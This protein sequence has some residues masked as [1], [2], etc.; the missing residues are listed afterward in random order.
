MR[1]RSAITWLTTLSVTAL[2]SACNSG[3]DGGGSSES[4]NSGV[5]K[6]K[7][8]QDVTNEEAEAVCEAFASYYESK[9]D[10][11]SFQLSICRWA[12]VYATASAAD[13]GTNLDLNDLCDLAYDACVDCLDNPGTEGC[14]D[15]PTFDFQLDESCTDS[16]PP[17]DCD[18]TVGE[19]ETCLK[20]EVDSIVG[21]FNG[22]PS[23]GSLTQ[24]DLDEASAG[25]EEP[26]LPGACTALEDT[27]PAVLE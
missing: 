5:Q 22:A 2:T 17:Q 12:A 25:L 24:T 1:L 6:S 15:F 21:V 19:V 16:E 9:L 10:S 18:A 27:C 13:G 14:E 3:S 11:R 26:D 23:C 20:A 4:L 7:S 8:V